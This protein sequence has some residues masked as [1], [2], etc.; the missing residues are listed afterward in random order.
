METFS[1]RDIPL[2]DIITVHPDALAAHAEEFFRLPSLETNYDLVIVVH[3]LPPESS[4]GVRVGLHLERL[5]EAFERF[6]TK[7]EQPAI[8][9]KEQFL[10]GVLK[11]MMNMHR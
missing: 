8:L 3:H 9:N 7:E 10:T 6:L 11:T 1:M 4:S 2:Q 5:G